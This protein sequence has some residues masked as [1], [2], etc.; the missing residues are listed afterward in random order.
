MVPL[1]LPPSIVLITSFGVWLL[2]CFSFLAF[3]K[4]DGNKY[5]LF[6]CCLMY[7]SK[8]SACL[9]NGTR[10]NRSPFPPFEISTCHTL[11][12]GKCSCSMMSEY[13]ALTVS[14]ALVA[15]SNPHKIARRTVCDMLARAR[16]IINSGKA[17]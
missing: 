5:S 15:L 12:L 8:V 2:I 14:L 9:L 7:E 11:P 4:V 16:L 17:L 10:C 1:Y 13:F 6:A 3:D